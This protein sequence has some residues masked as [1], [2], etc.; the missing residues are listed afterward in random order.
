MS[1]SDPSALFFKTAIRAR[2]VSFTVAAA[3]AASAAGNAN[4]ASGNQNEF[5]T[6]RYLTSASPDL[7]DDPSSRWF[8]GR[9]APHT[10]MLQEIIERSAYPPPLMPVMA[11]LPHSQD[12][13]PG[14]A[15]ILGTASMYNPNNAGDAD[16][17]N[18]ETA[19]GELYDANDWTA[20]IRTDL[21]AQFGG[22]R[23]GKNYRPVF[24]LVQSDDKQAIVRINDVGPLRPG[25]VID[26][27]ERAMRYFDPTLRR[28]LLED[29]RVVP[30]SGQAW[31]VGPVIE[32]P[33]V[34]V[35]SFDQR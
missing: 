35:A 19:S 5:D 21:R 33:P 14:A 11:S 4:A 27:N 7:I 30:L 29:V 18:G 17:G 25:R 9:F 23:F 31:A 28:G 2:V 20:A 32:E 16:S 3:L 10:S 12:L 15:P 8:A 24:A 22:V 13:I 26:L 34:N 1:F 6:M